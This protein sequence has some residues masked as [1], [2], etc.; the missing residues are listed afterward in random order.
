MPIKTDPRRDPEMLL[1]QAQAEEEYARRGRLKVFLG[2]TS[3]VGK[4]FRMFDEGRRRRER[5]QDVVVGAVQPKGSDDVDQLLSRLEVIPL[6]QC[7]GTGV[8]DVNRILARHPGVCLVDGLAYDNPVGCGN[9]KRWQDVDRLLNAG[10][11]VIT[12]INLQYI[13]EF[14]DRVQKI[15][16][17]R[18]SQ[19]VPVSFL[20]KADEI[21]IVDAPPELTLHRGDDP[22]GRGSSRLMTQEQLSD[23][24]ELAL[25]LAADVVDR[26][27]A[28]CLDRNGIAA[29]WGTQERILVCLTPRAN[30][31]RMIESGRRN[32][33]RFHGE[34]FAVYVTQGE[35]APEDQAALE[36]NLEIARQAGATV[37]I[38]EGVDPAEAIL[39]YA[40]SHGITQIFIGHS[41]QSGWWTRLSGTPVD[42]LLDRAENMDVRVFPQ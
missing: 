10:I 22:G 15:T 24:R 19:M 42:R 4:S 16:G 29:S 28:S 33:A 1:R 39:E 37:E 30:A 38:L 2:Y 36:R 34:L 41:R 23:M 8:M 40:R 9:P 17:K 12:T 35:T 11:S 3:G 25:L 27:L 7:G 32:A 5:G 21:A 26:Q 31:T 14:V 13:Y 20:L 18:A 6:L